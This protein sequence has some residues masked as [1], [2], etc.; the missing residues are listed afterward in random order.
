MLTSPPC[1]DLV[2]SLVIMIPS[3]PL[4]QLD[5][6]V[7]GMIRQDLLVSTAL[8][9][10]AY[11]L[12][13]QMVKHVMLVN[14]DMKGPVMNCLARQADELQRNI[15]GREVLKILHGYI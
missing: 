9:T 7:E 10:T 8:H 3:L 4:S 5:R 15:C 1:S 14:S 2:T 12:A 6:L 13:S 11:F